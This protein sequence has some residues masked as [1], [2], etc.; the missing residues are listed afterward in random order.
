MGV[1][2]Y[3]APGGAHPLNLRGALYGFAPAAKA[4]SARAVAT[5]IFP[6]LADWWK[7]IDT[8]D[9]PEQVAIG[10]AAA[11][12]RNGTSF[13]AEAIAG[14]HIGEE[15]LVDA[16]AETFG[17]VAEPE[18]EADALSLKD[19]QAALLLSDGG[20]TLLARL[21]EGVEARVLMA[22]R[23]IGEIGRA[24]REF[25]DLARRLRL[26]SMARLRKALLA[27]ASASLA[28]LATFDLFSQH[29]DFSA[30]VVVN[31]WQGCV[32]GALAIGLP[33]ALWFAPLFTFAALHVAFTVF[34]LACV[35]LRLAAVSA[36]SRPAPPSPAR[37]CPRD[38]PTYSVLVALYK[39]A[40]V[41]GDLI[42]ALRRL[43]WPASKLD[44]KLICEAD[45]R[46]TLDAIEAARP[47]AFF[48]TIVVPDFGPRTKPKA[49]NYALQTAR[50]EFVVLFDAEDRPHPR[51]LLEAWQRFQDCDPAVACLQ[52]PLEVTNGASSW[53]ARLFAFEYV[54]LFKGLLPWLSAQRLLLPLG[55][56]SNHFRRGAL[57]AVGCWDP[58]NVTED[59]DLGV[60]LMRFGY[61][62]ETIALETCEAA[63]ETLAVWVPQRT[64]WFKGWLQSWLVHM[65]D[66]L[67]TYRE[68]GPRSFLILQVLFGG[69]VLSALSHP[70][71]WIT[72][73]VIAG[74]LALGGVLSTYQSALLV[75]DTASIV[76][77]YVS[78][79][80]LGWQA[81]GRA[82]GWGMWKVV[83][84]TPL[85]WL[86]MSY[87]A[88]RSVLHLYR[89]P[90][91]WEKTP[92][93]AG[94]TVAA[95]R[96]ARL[97]L[98]SAFRTA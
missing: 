86:M 37:P 62:T 58:F 56:T 17:L 64:R 46:A 85:Y 52:A 97:R 90:H 75:L 2:E 19:Q 96:P 57:E 38:L 10:I 23:Q 87:A 49:L 34:F 11:A 25:P 71:L 32:V 14:G 16:V 36:G 95:A 8:A 9:I 63:P 24:D 18:I 81:A 31:A 1:V 54:A 13:A 69:M 55:G 51:Q 66:P 98:A 45:D 82:G 91:L 94:A 35:G 80:L 5:R 22:T 72:W 43:D 40:D 6:E 7:V 65:R 67:R 92:H 48:E 76:C 28:R 61:R 79:W 89:V 42:A 26:V 21:N 88:W 44:V 27:Q 73:L 60:R 20:S 4:S 78:F 68:L 53:V 30:R 50:G 59:A 74:H 12:Q 77:G 39:E 29:P 15:H 3:R 93:G 47:P 41:V 33:V 84:F 70:I 83:L